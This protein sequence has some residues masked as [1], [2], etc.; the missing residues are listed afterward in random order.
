M[1]TDDARHKNVPPPSIW[2]ESW[3]YT[4]KGMTEEISG[5]LGATNT[6][7][8]KSHSLIVKNS[9]TLFS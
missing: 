3:S 8:D 5:K 2:L 9:K 1:L 7:Q 6:T 4:I